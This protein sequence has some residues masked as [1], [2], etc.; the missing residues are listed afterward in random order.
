MTHRVQRPQREGRTTRAS[1]A[2]QPALRTSVVLDR[3]IQE[4]GTA[5]DPQ[6]EVPTL[7]RVLEFQESPEVWT[8]LSRRT[9]TA[10]SVRPCPPTS[11][12]LTVE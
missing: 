3:P 8:W 10:L 4:M 11:R 6:V 9:L 1:H 2:P 5:E 7:D 12:P